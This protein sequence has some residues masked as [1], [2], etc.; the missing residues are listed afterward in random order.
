MSL[1]HEQTNGNNVTSNEH[2]NINDPYKT[3]LH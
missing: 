1:D 2:L 3:F